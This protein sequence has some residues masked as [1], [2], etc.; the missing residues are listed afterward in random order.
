[1]SLYTPPLNEIIRKQGGLLDSTDFPEPMKK[2]LDAI[3]KRA[4]DTIRMVTSQLSI[5]YPIH[6]GIIDDF[7]FNAFATKGSEEYFIGINRGLIATVNLV[8]SRIFADPRLFPYLGDVSLESTELPLLERLAFRFEYTTEMLPLF[9][10]PKCPMRSSYAYH[11]KQLALDFI[12][13]HEI[14]HIVNGHVDYPFRNNADLYLDELADNSSRSVRI[15]MTSKALELD[16]DTWATEMLLT[17]EF[18]KCAGVSPYPKNMRFFYKRPGLVLIQFTQVIAVLFKIFGDHRLNAS[19][20]NSDNYP[21]PRLRFTICK[22]MMYKTTALNAV[23]K[24]MNFD[25]KKDMLSLGIEA[26][27]KD[28]EHA[29]EAITGK[30]SDNVGIEQSNGELGDSQIRSIIDYWNENLVDQL[31]SRARIKILPKEYF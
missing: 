27:F 18:L 17:S 9:D 21:K 5:T 20:F 31:S 19:T 3:S 16:A 13:A 11:L 26:G 24:K 14:T 28:I 8:F 12:L 1:M 30:P 22:R 4:T 7:G 2:S 29:F 25:M 6:F 15:G 10:P 23:A